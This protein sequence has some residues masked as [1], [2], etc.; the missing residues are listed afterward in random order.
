MSHGEIRVEDA[1]AL[2]ALK[3]PQIFRLLDRLRT[4]RASG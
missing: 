4:H 2:L 3:R 1:A